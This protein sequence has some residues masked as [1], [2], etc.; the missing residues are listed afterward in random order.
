[1]LQLVVDSSHENSRRIR[2]DKLKHIGHQVAYRTIY[3][4]VLPKNIA[5][6]VD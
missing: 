2:S 6:L 3:E 1:M 4:R 5:D